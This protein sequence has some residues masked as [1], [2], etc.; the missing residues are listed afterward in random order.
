MTC[1]ACRSHRTWARLHGLSRWRSWFRYCWT[2]GQ[3]RH[4]RLRIAGQLALVLIAALFVVGGLGVLLQI[5]RLGLDG[6]P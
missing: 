4:A 6:A 5:V 2:H 3:R 1:Y